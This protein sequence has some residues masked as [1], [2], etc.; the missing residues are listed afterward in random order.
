MYSPRMRRTSC[1]ALQAL[2]ALLVSL[3]GASMAVKNITIT[4]PEAVVQ[5]D[6]VTLRCDYDLED[7]NLYSIKW[8]RDESE[9]YQFVP[10]EIP[11]TK[12]FDV[13]GVKIKVDVSRSDANRVTIQD[14][15]RQPP[16]YY[17]CEVSA[18]APTF[19]TGLQTGLLTVI[20]SLAWSRYDGE[21]SFFVSLYKDS[22]HLSNL[23]EYYT[24][25]LSHEHAGGHGGHHGQDDERLESVRSSVQ[26][27]GHQSKMSLSCRATMFNVYQQSSV[28]VE[29][30]SEGAPKPAPVRKASSAANDASRTAASAAA[31]AP[32]V[33][34]AM[35]LRR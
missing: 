23:V 6:S 17:R 26:V 14:V 25:S 3:F 1:P 22:C 31:W 19:H 21:V 30:Q 33:L 34:V 12:V 32:L 28:K 2:C 8:F 4:L 16:A 13:D 18:D 20:G 35:V 11:A 10:K 27:T 5:G 29:L 24:E 9:F 15:G 7:Q